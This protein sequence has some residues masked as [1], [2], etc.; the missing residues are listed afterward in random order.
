MSSVD[1]SSA[2]PASSPR[3]WVL[4]AGGWTALCWLGIV[5]C[6]LVGAWPPVLLFVVALVPVSLVW[7]FRYWR[8]RRTPEVRVI[9][10][11][12]TTGL[13]ADHYLVGMSH[14]Q[15]TPQSRAEFNRAMA[16]ADQK[17]AQGFNPL[18]R[19]LQRGV[20]RGLGGMIA[21]FFLPVRDA[22]REYRWSRGH[23]KPPLL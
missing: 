6:V 7:R 9:R 1:P 2:V 8:A 17:Q 5:V 11:A 10:K 4:V 16:R 13:S 18:G 15:D 12:P 14:G 3:T 22:V 20:N 19:M 23:G 21:G